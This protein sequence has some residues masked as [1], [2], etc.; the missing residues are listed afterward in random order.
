MLIWK[1]L[2]IF[3]EGGGLG[4]RQLHQSSQACERDQKNV[5]ATCQGTG[6]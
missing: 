5:F 4:G 2:W 6:I 1:T 3:A